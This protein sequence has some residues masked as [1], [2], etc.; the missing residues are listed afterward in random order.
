MT[1][2]YNASLYGIDEAEFAHQVQVGVAAST[3]TGPAEH[4]PQGT[5]QVLIQGNQ[6][7][8]VGKLLLGEQT[9][10]SQPLEAAS[11]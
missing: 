1:L 4:K 2:V 10:D 11:H 5:T 9:L 3:S 8:F 6:V 7:A